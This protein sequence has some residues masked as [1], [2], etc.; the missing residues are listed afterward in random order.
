MVHE[1]QV[2][3]C[4]TLDFRIFG[5]GLNILVNVGSLDTAGLLLSLMIWM[6]S[7]IVEIAKLDQRFLF[8]VMMIYSHLE[9][10]ER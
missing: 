10:V 1:S 4:L 8:R 9:I 3:K 5:I 2:E 6:K 7:V